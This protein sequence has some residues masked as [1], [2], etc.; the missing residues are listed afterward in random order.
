MYMYS[1][2]SVC[3]C[4]LLTVVCTCVVEYTCVGTEPTAPGMARMPG[5][6]HYM[7]T[8]YRVHIYTCTYMYMYW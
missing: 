6:Y 8:V 5:C 3:V 4:V 2:A 1:S 7:Y